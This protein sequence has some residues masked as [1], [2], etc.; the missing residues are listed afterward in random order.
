MTLAVGMDLTYGDLNAVVGEDQGR[1]G[2]SELGVRHCEWILTCGW[3]IVK[4]ARSR[5]VCGLKSE[6]HQMELTTEI[7]V[8]NSVGGLSRPKSG[9]ER[10]I[11]RSGDESRLSLVEVKRTNERHF[12]SCLVFY[13][14][15][16]CSPP[17]A[18]SSGRLK[19]DAA[20]SSSLILGL[21]GV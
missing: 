5:V 21:E 4:S 3:E 1:V 7:L 13:P 17:L 2:R 19:L 12:C 8:R 16:S 10:R 15:F 14:T 6:Y 9:K 11:I 18:V 20:C